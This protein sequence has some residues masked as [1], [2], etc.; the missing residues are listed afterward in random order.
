MSGRK[1][2]VEGEGSD[3]LPIHPKGAG[4][5]RVREWEQWKA[6]CPGRVLVGG[7]GGGTMADLRPGPLPPCPSPP[8]EA[9]NSGSPRDRPR[10]HQD[11]DGELPEDLP[12]G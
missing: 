3:I 12:H 1:G 7:Y 5:L 2:S 9:P 10:R 4:P 11:G 8:P 6:L